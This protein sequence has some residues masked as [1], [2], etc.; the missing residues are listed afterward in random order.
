MGAVAAAAR[1]LP[2]SRQREALLVADL[3]RLSKLTLLH[4]ADAERSALLKN[5]VLP[6]LGRRAA[7]RYAGRCFEPS[8]VPFPDRRNYRDRPIEIAIYVDRWCDA[9]LTA[10]H[11]RIASALILHRLQVAPPF[12]A[13]PECLAEWS[14]RLGVRFLF[15]FDRF[16]RMS[17]VPRATPGIVDFEDAFVAVVNDPRI[18]ANFLLA[19]A[20]DAATALGR[21]RGRI[22]GF[23]DA[24]VRL[25]A[26]ASGDEVTPGLG[27]TA[28]G[29]RPAIEVEAPARAAPSLEP[30]PGAALSPAALFPGGVPALPEQSPAVDA[31][32]LRALDELDQTLGRP[33]RHSAV[34]AL[35]VLE[36]WQERFACSTGA[37]AEVRSTVTQFANDRRAAGSL[38]LAHA[39]PEPASAGAAPAERGDRPLPSSRSPPEREP[40]A[41]AAPAARSPRHRVSRAGL[42]WAAIGL[43]VAALLAAGHSLLSVGALADARHPVDRRFPTSEMTGAA[44]A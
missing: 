7:D 16:D 3:L 39:G 33:A 36:V 23:G 19:T 14:T 11:T 28:S 10:L 6:L 13:L 2:E 21:Y 32:A 1:S 25:A 12:P 5:G 8:V 38:P 42:R 43:I 37:P 41:T 24:S 31:T 27:S 30:I 35:A 18:P 26:A 44:M 34:E 17:A 29:S 15:I 22:P 40:E 4:G 20:D 9:P